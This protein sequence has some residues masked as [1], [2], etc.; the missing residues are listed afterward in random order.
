MKEIGESYKP[1]S[2]LVKQE[3]ELDEIYE[4]TCETREHERLL[5]VKNDVLSIAFCYARYTMR[6]EELTNFGMQYRLTLPSLAKLFFS[7]S[8]DE[9]DEP[10][11]TYTNSFM[12]NFVSRSI[13]GGSCN[14]FNQHY[15]SEISG[16]VFIIISK[17]LDVNG[18]VCEILE[19]FFEFLNKNEKLY[20]KK[21]DTE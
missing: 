11:Y 1:Q 4:D 21:F 3:L 7:S 15:I 20:A 17:Q 2:C 13:K 12:R 19:K 16:E 6:M 8:R 18:N 10:I 14:A 5:Y 9:N